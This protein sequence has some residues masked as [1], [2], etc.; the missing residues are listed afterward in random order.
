M[1]ENPKIGEK[2]YFVHYWIEDLIESCEI[3]E[4]WRKD[5]AIK[6]EDGEIYTCH[7][8]DLYNSKD[9]AKNV[10]I[11]QYKSVIQINQERL[12][13]IKFL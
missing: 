3:T 9:E 1:I 5:F 6:T 13:R 4:I 7:A 11:S 8:E 10:L 12:E 2:Y